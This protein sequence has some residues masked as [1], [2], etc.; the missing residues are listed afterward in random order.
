MV[1][2]V[3]TDSQYLLQQLEILAQVVAA[4]VGKI[5]VQMYWV[6]LAVLALS[7]FAT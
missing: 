4:Q 2:Q 5:Q 1:A 7:L 3:L 6:V